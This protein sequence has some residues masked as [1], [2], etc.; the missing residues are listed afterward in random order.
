MPRRKKEAPRR[1]VIEGPIGVGK[2]TFAKALA[3]HLGARLVLEEVDENP[4]IQRFYAEPEVYGFQTQLFFL[5]SRYRQQVA[6]LQ[7]DLFMRNTVSDYLFQKDRIFAYLNLGQDEL[8]L[9]EKVYGLLDA[10]I[11]SPDLVV[12][13]QASTDVLMERIRLRG[14]EWERSLTES[15]LERLSRAYAD[16]FWHYDR[17]PLLTVNTS[18]IDIVEDER[19]LEDLIGA[20]RRMKK[21]VQ[22]YHPITRG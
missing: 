6:L 13:L 19:D 15:Y 16:Y 21:G 7:E 20:V 18:D 22:V 14:R 11:P 5:L 1:I 10:R 17:S 8:A 12:Y 2:T 4:F 9:Y 3:D